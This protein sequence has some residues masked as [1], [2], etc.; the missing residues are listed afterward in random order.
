MG[1]EPTQSAWKAE[2]LPL[3]Y[4][5]TF[6]ACI[7]YQSFHHKSNVFTDVCD[8]FLK[9]FPKI[10]MPFHRRENLIDPFEVE[11]N[12]AEAVVAR[13]HGR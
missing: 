6:N 3:N 10:F 2:I 1:V 7:F 8:F 13:D 4:T 11:R 9:I 12:G 5:R